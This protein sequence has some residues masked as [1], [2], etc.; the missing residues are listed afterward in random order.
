MLHS[1]GAAG[2][3]LEEAN[4]ADNRPG[5]REGTTGSSEPQQQDRRVT[6]GRTWNP[7]AHGENKSD[8]GRDY[9]GIMFGLDFP[10]S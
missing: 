5:P 10:T 8:L 9:V 3:V 7:A 4:G 1:P 6:W 2:T